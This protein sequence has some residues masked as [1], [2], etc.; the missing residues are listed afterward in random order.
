[1]LITYMQ[2][3]FKYVDRFAVYKLKIILLYELI[4][5]TK[6]NEDFCTVDKWILLNN[7][8]SFSTVYPH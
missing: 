2:I 7:L 4:L 8:T 6:E 5:S 3:V 1:M